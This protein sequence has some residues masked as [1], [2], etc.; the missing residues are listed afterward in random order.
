MLVNIL[1]IM[2]L[3]T[4]LASFPSPY[5]MSYDTWYR[6]VI[7][8]FSLIVCLTGIWQDKDKMQ[9]AGCRMREMWGLEPN[10]E[11]GIWNES[12]ISN[13]TSFCHPGA[14]LR[15]RVLYGGTVSSTEYVMPSQGRPNTGFGAEQLETWR[16]I[17]YIIHI[18]GDDWRTLATSRSASHADKQS[19]LS[20]CQ[21]LSSSSSSCHLVIPFL[22]RM[23]LPVWYMSPFRVQVDLKI[24]ICEGQIRLGPW[25]KERKEKKKIL[26]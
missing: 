14:T 10:L 11:S 8:V 15:P 21:Y 25:F 4:S 2:W 3:L 24:V 19:T 20:S 1:K 9:D 6:K 16:L 5:H 18:I 26:Q 12:G 23:D 13:L 17:S 22:N 7:D